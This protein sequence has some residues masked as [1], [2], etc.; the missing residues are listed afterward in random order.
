[1]KCIKN[2]QKEFYAYWIEDYWDGW[3]SAYGTFNNQLVYVKCKDE[4]KSPRIFLFYPITIPEYE[5]A[6]K[7][8]RIFEECVGKHWNIIDGNIYKRNDEPYIPTGK[9]HL[10]YDVDHSDYYNLLKRICS[11]EPI[12]LYKD[13]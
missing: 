4:A 12:A 9:V 2:I 5:I 8:H 1:M 3:L 7:R 6:E 11:R 10:H 13:G